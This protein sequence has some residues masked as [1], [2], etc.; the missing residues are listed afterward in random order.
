MTALKTLFTRIC[1][2]PLRRESTFT[3]IFVQIKEA[4]K[5][6]RIHGSRGILITPRLPET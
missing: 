5:K 2:W 6:V 1:Y 4:C 3:A